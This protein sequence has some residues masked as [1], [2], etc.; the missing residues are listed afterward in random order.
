MSLCR[1]L[2][3]TH[4]ASSPLS[5]AAA[6][7][8]RCRQPK[9]CASTSTTSTSPSPITHSTT[10]KPNS[11]SRC[12]RTSFWSVFTQCTA[13]S[14]FK[15]ARV[16][17]SR[18]ACRCCP[19]VLASSSRAFVLLSCTH[20]Y[21]SFSEFHGV[22]RKPCLEAP[23]RSHSVCSHIGLRTS[24]SAQ[25]KQRQQQ[26]QRHH[27]DCRRHLHSFCCANRRSHVFL[28]TAAWRQ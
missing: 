24:F 5:S 27:H 23:S 11:A 6:A 2:T 20:F 17:S 14:S 3:L 28:V 26:Q 15:T 25:C 19:A 18:P 7:R 4:R 21:L 10:W 22:D 9:H 8:R 1:S 12:H 16:H 13:T